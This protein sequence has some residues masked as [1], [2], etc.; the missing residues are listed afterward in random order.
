MFSWL[1]CAGVDLVVATPGRLLHLNK[2]GSLPLDE[3]SY[4]V[5]DE[6]DKFMQGSMEEELRKV[7]CCSPS[8]LKWNL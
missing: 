4:F 2:E 6:A 3:V 7:C 1:Y 5:V 8:C